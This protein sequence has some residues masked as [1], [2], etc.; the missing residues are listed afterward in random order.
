MFRSLVGVADYETVR[1]LIQ[2]PALPMTKTT[3]N[4]FP[5]SHSFM[6]NFRE[7]Y[8]YFS[9]LSYIYFRRI[10]SWSAFC[11]QFL[12]LLRSF[13]LMLRQENA[14]GNFFEAE[15]TVHSATVHFMLCSHHRRRHRGDEGI[16]PP[17]LFQHY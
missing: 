16:D 2:L 4:L 11:Q 3:T 7:I 15:Q 10:N 14:R 12:N 6:T 8:K 9:K 1:T 17:L 5:T 13:C